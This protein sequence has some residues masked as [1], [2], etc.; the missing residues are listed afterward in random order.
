MHFEQNTSVIK[1]NSLGFCPA[2]GF[3]QQKCVK[4]NLLQTVMDIFQTLSAVA[5]QL[6]LRR[7]DDF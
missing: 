5:F 6:L 1:Q 4:Q 3:K 7:L 2:G